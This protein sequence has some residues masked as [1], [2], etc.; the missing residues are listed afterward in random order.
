MKVIEMKCKQVCSLAS[1]YL[2]G[3]LPEGK[4]AEIRAHLA[5]CESCR[6]D[7]EATDRALSALRAP[8]AVFEPPDVLAEVKRRAAAEPVRGFRLRPVFAAWAVAGTAA[9][10]AVLWLALSWNPTTPVVNSPSVV[11]APPAQ[12]IPA[13]EVANP[14]V[15]D[16]PAGSETVTADEPGP[17]SVKT[18]APKRKPRVR[19]P[20]PQPTPSVPE[21][22]DP[23]EYE[24][25]VEYIMV[26]TP[27]MPEPSDVRPES[28]VSA[29]MALASPDGL[30]GAATANGYEGT[31]PDNSSYSIRMVDNA[32]GEITT[33][34]VY[35]ETVPGGEPNGVIEYSVMPIAATPDTDERSS[36]D[37]THPHDIS[38]PVLVLG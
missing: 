32:N 6:A 25:T 4:Q 17:A 12:H 22:A 13:P 31:L 19:S 15:E 38:A 10:I 3:D 18:P 1:E 11:T 5:D 7:V 23:I 35:T 2:A 8:R 27:D 30:I 16:V 24:P 36:T 21:P 20:R 29:D 9:L 28:D 26:Y 33:L 37:G 34:N 14:P